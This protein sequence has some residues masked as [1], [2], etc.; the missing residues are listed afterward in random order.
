MRFALIFF[1]LPLHFWVYC[2]YEAVDTMP[3]PEFHRSFPIG[4]TI[5]MLTFRMRSVVPI[6]NGSSKSMHDVEIFPITRRLRKLLSLPPPFMRTACELRTV[7]LD[8]VRNSI[9]ST[10]N[11][12][13]SMKETTTHDRPCELFVNCEFALRGSDSFRS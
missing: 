4:R 1:Y 2:F 12:N 8:G 13:S 5:F 3:S 11:Q 9:F 7:A 6:R 10:F